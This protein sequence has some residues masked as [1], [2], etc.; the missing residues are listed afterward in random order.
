MDGGGWSELLPRI[1]RLLT[2][3]EPWLDGVLGHR[4]TPTDSWAYRWHRD[5]LEPVQEPDLFRLE[6]LIGV[7]RSVGSATIWPS[8]RGIQPIESSSRPWTG[9]WKRGLQTR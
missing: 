9:A 6:S 8:R 1:E 2:R 3:V 5:R 7:E 4:P